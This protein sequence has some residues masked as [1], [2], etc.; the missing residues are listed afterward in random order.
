M[1]NGSYL[2]I[3]GW[4]LLEWNLESREKLKPWG[5]LAEQTSHQPSGHVCVF[6][7]QVYK[8]VSCFSLHVRRDSNPDGILNATFHVVS[9]SGLV[10]PSLVYHLV[11]SQP[12]SQSEIGTFSLAYYTDLMP[13]LLLSE[14]FQELTVYLNLV[15]LGIWASS[16]QDFQYCQRL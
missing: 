7:Q 1:A 2:K 12:H 10:H 5:Q 13:L 8:Y 4:G 6:Y 3:R 11:P 14:Y 15:K 16:C 9:F